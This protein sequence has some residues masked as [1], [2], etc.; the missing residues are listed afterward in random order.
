MAYTSIC[1][2]L[3]LSDSDEIGFRSTCFSVG[4]ECLKSSL[5]ELWKFNYSITS[6]LTEEEVLNTLNQPPVIY[7]PNTNIPFSIGS[8]LGSLFYFYSFIQPLTKSIN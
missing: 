6:Q 4:G 8:V 5:F 7:N 1:R 2:I 3:A